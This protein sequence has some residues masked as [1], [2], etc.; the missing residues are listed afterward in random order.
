M[1]FTENILILPSM[2]L[3]S[4]S[5]SLARKIAGTTLRRLA[6]RPSPLLFACPTGA[7]A[8]DL[9]Y[10]LQEPPPNH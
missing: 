10:V 8:T 5:L 6:P 3:D 1:I 7:E 9:L 4:Q 2:L